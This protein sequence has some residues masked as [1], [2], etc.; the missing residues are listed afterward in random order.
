MS[1]LN[2]TIV[3]TKAGLD[4]PW[5]KVELAASPSP[6]SPFLYFLNQIFYW[7]CH[8]DEEWVEL[9]PSPSPQKFVVLNLEAAIQCPLVIDSTL[10]HCNLRRAPT[11][12]RTPKI[13]AGDGEDDDG[14]GPPS[15]QICIS[16]NY[17]TSREEEMKGKV[18]YKWKR[19][20]IC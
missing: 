13:D 5:R 7:W 15:R 3:A 18:G 20:F 10:H 11:N 2:E 12:Y 9:A 8:R 17:S 14:I 6:W 4:Q 1:F 19:N 16:S